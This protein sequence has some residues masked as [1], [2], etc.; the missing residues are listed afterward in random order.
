ME[1]IS[2]AWSLLLSRSVWQGRAGEW[3]RGCWGPNPHVWGLLVVISQTSTNLVPHTEHLQAAWTRQTRD[4]LHICLHWKGA[5]PFSLS[6][7]HRGLFKE[8]VKPSKNKSQKAWSAT[9]EAF[10]TSLSPSYRAHQDWKMGTCKFHVKIH[11]W[12]KLKMMVERIC[13]H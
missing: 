2:A 11:S 4:H 6:K 12:T 8:A 5:Q 9:D 3:S 7:K 1:Q 10:P 13:F